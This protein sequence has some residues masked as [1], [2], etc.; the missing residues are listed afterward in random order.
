MKD[1]KHI[2]GNDLLEILAAV[3]MSTPDKVEMMI[4]MPEDLGVDVAQIEYDSDLG[5][6]KKKAKK[7]AAKNLTTR[8]PRAPKQMKLQLP[9]GDGKSPL[10]RKLTAPGLS[11]KDA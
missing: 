3:A 6:G 5:K 9:E 4:D 10:E 1:V 7:P 2:S 11:S 8:A